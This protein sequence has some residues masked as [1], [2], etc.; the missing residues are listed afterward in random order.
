VHEFNDVLTAIKQRTSIRGYADEPVSGEQLSDLT[1]WA[2]SV[3][4]VVPDR[5]RVALVRE[6]ARAQHILTSIVGSYG[7]IQN[8]PHLLVG[9]LSEESDL[10][11]IDLGYT[12]EQVV[13]KATDVG[14]GTCWST[15]TYDPKR[16]GDTLGLGGTEIAAAVCA[17]GYF[18]Q[19]GWRQFHSRAFHQITGGHRRKPLEKIVF[20]RHWGEP[21]SPETSDPTLVSVLEHARLAPSA[22]NRQPWRFIVRPDDV[23]LALVRPAPIDAGIVMSHIALASAALEREGQ[24]EVR[25]GDIAL[26]QACRLPKDVIPVALFG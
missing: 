11:R 1:A 7:L 15:G 3:D 23:V 17:L 14:L 20:S 5:A 26:A 8:A 4:H 10:G 9:I 6:K 12:L 16:A 22:V 19:K 13:L 21:W 2:E 25:F 24:W 18:A